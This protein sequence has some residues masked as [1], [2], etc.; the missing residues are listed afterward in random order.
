MSIL[1]V[2][3][4]HIL[5]SQRSLRPRDT[6]ATP[7]SYHSDPIWVRDPRFGNPCSRLSFK[8]SNAITS[9]NAL[10]KQLYPGE[11]G[12]YRLLWYRLQVQPDN[13]DQELRAKSISQSPLMARCLL[14]IALFV[15]CSLTCIL[16]C[17]GRLSTVL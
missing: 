2:L 4:I 16:T 13:N 7:P 17:L 5:P 14:L 10:I 8:P 12:Q 3:N 1:D 9:I 6:F 15:Y 11:V